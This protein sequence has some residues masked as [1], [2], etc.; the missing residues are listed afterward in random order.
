MKLLVQFLLVVC[1]RVLSTHY[2]LPMQ[3]TGRISCL[4]SNICTFLGRGMG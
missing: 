4:Y 2:L 1:G 3:S